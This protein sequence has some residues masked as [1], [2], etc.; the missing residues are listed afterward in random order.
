MLCAALFLALLL[1]SCAGDEAAEPAAPEAD[2]GFALISSTLDW[3]G[4]RGARGLLPENTIPSY[5]LAAEMG[6][7]T[8]ELDVVMSSDGHVVVSHEP[9]MSETICSHPDG[10]PVAEDEAHDL[11]IY[12]MTYDEVAAFD[13]GSRGHAGYPHQEPMAVSKPLLG[14]TIA[15]LEA[16]SDSLGRPPL[17]YNIEIK[18]RP[19]HDGVYHPDVETFAAAVH[20]VMEQHGIL[21][22]ST[23][24][25]FDPR[26]VNAVMRIDPSVTVALLVSNEDGLDANLARL[27]ELPDIYS[28]NQN[29]VDSTLVADLRQKG[30]LVIP[31]TVNT[32]GDMQRLID[33]GV[34]GI[35]TDYPDSAW[36]VANA[37][38]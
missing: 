12:R 3:Q 32:T 24:Q 31:W 11:N 22:R 35:I 18:S 23:I 38:R 27:S 2:D 37:N 36:V 30:L 8:V 21:D 25:S 33:L 10:S 9:W 14:E 1:A 4:H 17:R 28:P 15:D 26:T 7:T 13:C 20:D 16:F 34:D 29:L 5:R 19:E 6:V